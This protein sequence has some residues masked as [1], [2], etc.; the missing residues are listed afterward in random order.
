MVS[1]ELGCGAQACPASVTISEHHCSVDNN[2]NIA[3][4]SAKHTM[5]DRV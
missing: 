2:G 5:H 4:P 3:G 1:L